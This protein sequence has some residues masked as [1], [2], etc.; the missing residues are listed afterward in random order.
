M[1]RYSLPER[2]MAYEWSVRT[3]MPVRE[4]RKDWEWTLHIDAIRRAYNYRD[5]FTGS[6]AES[7]AEAERAEAA[8]ARGSGQPRPRRRAF[9]RA[10]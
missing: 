5:A 7:L 8:R 4:Q 1:K 6:L 3:T 10:T 2:N 9:S